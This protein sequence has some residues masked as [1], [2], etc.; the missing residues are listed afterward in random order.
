VTNSHQA[1]CVAPFTVNHA[2][3]IIKLIVSIQQDEFNINITAD[4]QP[5]LKD[6]PGFYQKGNGNFWLA[7]H[8]KKV[9]G[10][11]SLLDIGDN[12]AALRKMFVHQDFR[13]SSHGT[14][15]LLL[16]SLL[17][18]AHLKNISDI[19]LGTTV[20][21]LAAHRFYEKNGFTEIEKQRLPAAFPVMTVDTRFYQYSISR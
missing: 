10:S 15:G 12:Q 19:F 1:I 11:I 4:D 8:G 21:F 17:K 5:D 20:K 14:A 18:W 7:M 9:I 3:D 16:E 2:D 13:G 6:I